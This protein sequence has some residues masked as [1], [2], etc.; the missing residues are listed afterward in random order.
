MKRIVMMILLLCFSLSF[1]VAFVQHGTRGLDVSATNG[2]YHRLII[3]EFS[4]DEVMLASGIGMPFNLAGQDVQYTAADKQYAGREIAEWSVHSNYTPIT[5]K[6]KAE[7][8]SLSKATGSNSGK[9]TDGL[10]YILFFP[11]VFENGGNLVSG[12][13]KVES[14]KEYDSSKAENPISQNYDD[15]GINTSFLPIRFM[16]KEDVDLTAFEPGIYNATV[17]ITMEGTE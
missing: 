11:Y 10:G 9:E 7:D 14:G 4:D 3:R 1:S 6:I 5:I 2:K 8:L 17:T 15:N 16:L 12:F 13:M